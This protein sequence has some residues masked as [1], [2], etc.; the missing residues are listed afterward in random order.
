MSLDII[1]NLS[2]SE[3][4]ISWEYTPDADPPNN[5]NVQCI[6]IMARCEDLYIHDDPLLGLVWTNRRGKSTWCVNMSV[7]RGLY[8][9]A[10]EKM[11]GSRKRVKKAIRIHCIVRP[12]FKFLGNVSFSSVDGK[13]QKSN[14][15]APLYSLLLKCTHMKI[16]EVWRVELTKGNNHPKLYAAIKETDDDERKSN[17]SS[18]YRK[19]PYACPLCFAC[20]GVSANKTQHFQTKEHLSYWN[21]VDEEKKKMQKDQFMLYH[22]QYC[23]Y[24]DEYIRDLP[25]GLLLPVIKESVMYT[26]D[27][28]DATF[29]NFKKNAEAHIAT[30]KHIK[31]ASRHNKGRKSASIQLE[32]LNKFNHGKRLVRLIRD[33]YPESF[34][35]YMDQTLQESHMIDIVLRARISI[36]FYSDPDF[37]DKYINFQIPERYYEFFEKKGDYSN[38]YGKYKPGF[39]R[40]DQTRYHAELLDRRSKREE[41]L[42][43]AQRTYWFPCNQDRDDAYGF[44]LYLS[45]HNQH[46][47]ELLEANRMSTRYYSNYTKE[48]TLY[49]KFALFRN[50]YMLSSKET[51]RAYMAAMLFAFRVIYDKGKNSGDGNGFSRTKQEMTKRIK[52]YNEFEEG[53]H[54]NDTS[55]M[56]VLFFGIHPE[57]YIYPSYSSIS[58]LQDSIA[59]LNNKI[60]E[61]PDDI[62]RS[63]KILADEHEYDPSTLPGEVDMYLSSNDSEKAAGL[64]QRMLKKYQESTKKELHNLEM[65]IK[66]LQTEKKKIKR[67]GYKSQDD[68][69]EMTSIDN[70][71]NETQRDEISPKEKY[72][73]Q[74]EDTIMK[75]TR[76]IKY[77]NQRD[78]DQATLNTI[79]GYKHVKKLIDMN[80]AD[81]L[82]IFDATMGWTRFTPNLSKLDRLEQVIDVIEQCAQFIQSG[83]TL[84]QEDECKFHMIIIQF[85]RHFTGRSSNT[86]KAV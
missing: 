23:I 43:L 26:I 42:N 60:R 46:S 58:T 51:Y 74:I 82:V 38:T 32:P 20:V 59:E 71:I 40:S 37:V 16:C 12:E 57:K 55:H 29:E 54:G 77:Y 15:P 49:T 33:R 63:I 14:V 78:S 28:T 86:K 9:K 53:A 41:W 2:E 30:P 3:Q 68:Y 83:P 35:T 72:I 70:E 6:F 80:V 45:T 36:D 22:F 17:T 79:N 67:K 75:C 25:T 50:H 52:L 31:N 13:E 76:V 4:S 84:K 66:S 62:K 81:F 73:R 18:Q 39:Y 44:A 7:H 47:R 65:Y 10:I 56:Q 69:N 61:F 27:M 21:N 11:F 19:A 8:L 85:A 64:I 5:L 34:K 48:S 1:K 24:C